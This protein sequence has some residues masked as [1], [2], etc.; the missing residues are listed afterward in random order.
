MTTKATSLELL[1]RAADPDGRLTQSQ[2]KRL[3]DA[4]EELRDTIDNAIDSTRTYVEIL[5]DS[6]TA[7][8]RS[9]A[10]DAMES[11]TQSMLFELGVW[12]S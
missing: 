3:A 9:D 5:A 7:D 8:E 11:D 4:M 12:K 6:S 10:R 1:T 2:A